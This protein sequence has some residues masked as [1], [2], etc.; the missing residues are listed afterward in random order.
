M[1]THQKEKG[2]GGHLCPLLAAHMHLIL[3]E[4]FEQVGCP[5]CSLLHH[6]SALSSLSFTLFLLKFSSQLAE[7]LQ[8]AENESMAKIADLEKQLCQ[9]RHEL[10]S[11]KAKTAEDEQV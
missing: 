4:L 1:L 11:L 10:E 3:S 6:I 2:L 8:D 7:K 9:S 5:P